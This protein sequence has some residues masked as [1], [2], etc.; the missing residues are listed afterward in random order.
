MGK[1]ATAGEII[2]WN[3]VIV[4]ETFL[5]TTPSRR[6]PS[7]L[8]LPSLGVGGRG[9]VG[10]GRTGLFT[11]RRC[12]TRHAVDKLRRRR[13]FPS[14]SARVGDATTDLEGDVTNDCD[15]RCT[16]RE[17][18]DLIKGNGESEVDKLLLL[19]R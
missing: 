19:F 3:A 1:S 16:G 13:A 2:F 15:L 8:L 18:D 17:G 9:I 14:A 7:G 12:G 5:K 6:R 4:K 10:G 11:N